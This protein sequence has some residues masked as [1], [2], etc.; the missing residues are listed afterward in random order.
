MA[1]T[2]AAFAGVTFDADPEAEMVWVRVLKRGDGKISTGEHDPQ[3]GD[4]LY[5]Q[6]DT[7][8][9][10]RN[11][12]EALEERD[13]VEIGNYGPTMDHDGDGAPG[14]GVRRGPGRPP[15]VAD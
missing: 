7:F 13:F 15:K 11:V 1:K 2:K 12:A 3:G 5:E 9:V 10:P 6:G 14:G 8:S 4:F